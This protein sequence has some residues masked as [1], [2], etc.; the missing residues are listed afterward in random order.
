MQISGSV[1]IYNKM[2]LSAHPTEEFEEHIQDS[3]LLA[4]TIL[5]SAALATR[6]PTDSPLGLSDPLQSGSFPSA[7]PAR[8]ELLQ[9]RLCGNAGVAVH[10]REMPGGICEVSESQDAAFPSK[11]TRHRTRVA[12]LA[13]TSSC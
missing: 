9:H 5:V 12:F 7:S 1:I 6:V 11:L 4:S 3:A 2:L 8:L 13:A 10:A